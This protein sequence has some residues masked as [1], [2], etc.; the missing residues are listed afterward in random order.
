MHLQ[1]L[2]CES[3]TAVD[4]PR[5]KKLSCFKNPTLL[6]EFISITDS[7]SD[8]PQQNVDATAVKAD[9]EDW[10][11]PWMEAMHLKALLEVVE[12]MYCKCRSRERF[13]LSKVERHVL[14]SSLYITNRINY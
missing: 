6:N 11:D 5:M 4:G 7:Q 13:R 9:G 12:Q 10:Q 3:A 1:P 2:C 8:Q 14:Y